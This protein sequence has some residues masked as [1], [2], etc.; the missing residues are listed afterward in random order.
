MVDYDATMKP[1]PVFFRRQ[2]SYGSKFVGHHLR[3]KTSP[4]FQQSLLSA[5]IGWLNNPYCQPQ[6]TECMI[7]KPRQFLRRLRGINLEEAKNIALG[8]RSS[9]AMPTKA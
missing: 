2:M 1:K 8:E 4:N 3:A 9:Q 5:P 7:M 6:Y